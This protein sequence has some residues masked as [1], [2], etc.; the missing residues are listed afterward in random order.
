MRRDK[1][2]KETPA[3]HKMRR[4]QWGD[5]TVGDMNG[6]GLRRFDPEQF[7][8]QSWDTFAK[9]Q[10]VDSGAGRGPTMKDRARGERAIKQGQQGND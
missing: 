4:E 10:F 1:E 2:G 9:D 3:G 5:T 6:T 7:P 8:G